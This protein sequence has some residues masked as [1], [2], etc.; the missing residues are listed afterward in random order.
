MST[1]HFC[2]GNENIP[3]GL[4][5]IPWKIVLLMENS[6]FMEKFPSLLPA[7]AQNYSNNCLWFHVIPLKSLSEA[8]RHAEL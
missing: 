4:E 2:T 3:G 5:D 1:I 8:H 6:Y 7:T